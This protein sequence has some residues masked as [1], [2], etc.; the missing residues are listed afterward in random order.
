MGTRLG[1]SPIRARPVARILPTPVG[2]QSVRSRLHRSGVHRTVD[3]AVRAA[4][5]SAVR[6]TVQTTIQP[7]TRSAH[8]LPARTKI[9]LVHLPV[10]IVI[11]A[12]ANLD[13]AL[14]HQGIRIVTVRPSTLIGLKT[15]VVQI[16]T[17]WVLG[18][19]EGCVL[20]GCGC[21]SGGP[22]ELG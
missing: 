7:H 17:T 2:L 1:H 20:A 14:L 21:A 22:T 18:R 3:S 8:T 11:L 5:H 4:V 16:E 12:V 15:V 13:S 19:K 9:P 6:S 10:T